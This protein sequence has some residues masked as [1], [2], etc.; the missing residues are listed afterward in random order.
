MTVIT[1]SIPIFC[2]SQPSQRDPL[3]DQRVDC[4]HRNIR[5]APKCPS[6]VPMGKKTTSF[7]IIIDII[8]L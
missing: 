2:H 4:K 8:S 3:H 6:K 7:L 5:W 1:V